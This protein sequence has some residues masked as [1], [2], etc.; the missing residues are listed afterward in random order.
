MPVQSVHSLS[1]VL[2][3]LRKAQE[4]DRRRISIEYILFDG[5]N[6]LPRHRRE[7]AR[8]LQ[9]LKARVNL[10]HFHAIPGSPLRPSPPRVMEEF[11][12]A[13]V[14]KGIPAS[15]R[16]S[17]GEDIQA[18]CGLLSTKEFLETQANGDR[19]Y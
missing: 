5:V 19:D 2:A 16:R 14:E 1:Q 11:R 10:I 7:L 9:G 8:I 6:D 17:R 13:L 3:F 18:A 4:A 15:L 12:A